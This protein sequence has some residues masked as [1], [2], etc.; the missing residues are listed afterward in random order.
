MLLGIMRGRTLAANCTCLSFVSRC[1]AA[2]NRAALPALHI[3]TSGNTVL[4]FVTV[5]LKRG[6]EGQHRNLRTQRLDKCLPVAEHVIVLEEQDVR[7]VNGDFRR[8]LAQSDSHEGAEGGGR[9]RRVSITR[10]E[11]LQQELSRGEECK[12]G[13]R[14][15]VDNTHSNGFIFHVDNGQLGLEGE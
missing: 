13:A 14:E 8:D 7:Q 3:G 9:V 10:A 6:E 15:E 4:E 1:E 2:S 5:S 11:Q 12:E